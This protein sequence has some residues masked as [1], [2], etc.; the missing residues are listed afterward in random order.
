MK[1]AACCGAVNP[2]RRRVDA[3][4]FFALHGATFVSVRTDGERVYSACT[5]HGAPYGMRLLQHTPL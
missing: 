1:S 4:S 5:N 2:L 3:L